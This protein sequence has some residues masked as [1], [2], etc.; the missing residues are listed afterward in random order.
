[1]RTARLVVSETR[2]LAWAAPLCETDAQSGAAISTSAPFGRAGGACDNVHRGADEVE[3]A[4]NNMGRAVHE[5]GR[6]QYD[7]DY[8]AN[9]CGAALKDRALA[10]DDRGNDEHLA[11]I[12]GSA[13]GMSSASAAAGEV[14]DN[15]GYDRLLMKLSHAGSLGCKLENASLRMAVQELHDIKKDARQAEMVARIQQV[16]CTREYWARVNAFCISPTPTDGISLYS[17][18][19]DLPLF[20]LYTPLATPSL[21]LSPLY[22]STHHASCIDK[23][24]PQAI[25]GC[26]RC[27]ASSASFLHAV[28]QRG[29]V[30]AVGSEDDEQD[31]DVDQGDGERMGMHRDDTRKDEEGPGDAVVKQESIE[32]VASEQDQVQTMKTSRHREQRQARRSNDLKVQERARGHLRS[33]LYL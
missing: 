6:V 1:M 8:S 24:C 29:C 30:H 3:G 28:R 21:P 20:R 14:G 5:M 27:A 19:L 16:C 17:F 22:V 33:L 12:S 9:R 10:N 2:A 31:E 26:A 11:H 23:A 18:T 25:G 7:L 13:A 4:T 15:A 32:S